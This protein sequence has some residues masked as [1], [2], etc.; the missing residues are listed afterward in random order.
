M[1]F[2][3]YGCLESMFCINYCLL[4]PVR[5][6]EIHW[7]CLCHHGIPASAL[8]VFKPRL[9]DKG[10]SLSG[11]SHVSLNVWR[12]DMELDC[13]RSGKARVISHEMTA[14]SPEYSLVR[15]CDK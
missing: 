12:G 3:A 6:D 10:P 4:L 14:S 11:T 5:H 2:L 13:C 1:W 8:E 15:S 9:T 7:T